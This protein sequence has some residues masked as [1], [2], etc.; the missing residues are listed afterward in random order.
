MRSSVASALASTDAGRS[1][2]QSTSVPSRTSGHGARER[3]QRDDR[4]EARLAA[5]SVPPY[6]AMSRKRWSDSQTESKPERARRAAR[7]RAIVVE[8]QRATRPATE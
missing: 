1:A 2:S 5:R 6:F 8:P 3:G 4:L 7:S